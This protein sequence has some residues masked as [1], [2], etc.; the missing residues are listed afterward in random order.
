MHEIGVC[1]GLIA[2]VEK[3]AAGRPVDRVRFRA[4]V[5]HRIDEASLLQ[6]FELV[7]AGTVADGAELELVTLPVKVCCR[8]C[9]AV[10]VADDMVV[11]CGTCGATELDLVG[12]DELVLESIQIPAPV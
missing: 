6:A 11:C 4:G 1:E 12:G 7:S 8:S 9:A 10:T 2:T 3:R 5:L